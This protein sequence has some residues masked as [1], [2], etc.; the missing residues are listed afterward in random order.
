MEEEGLR[1]RGRGGRTGSVE[2]VV[3]DVVLKE[4][5]VGI[6]PKDTKCLEDMEHSNR[7]VN[8]IIDKSIDT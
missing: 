2:T 6:F 4:F 3:D 7:N 5:E 8:N 1:E